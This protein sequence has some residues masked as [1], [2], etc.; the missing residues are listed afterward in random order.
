MRISI[1]HRLSL[2][3]KTAKEGESL[4]LFATLNTDW[5]Q[6]PIQVG[7]HADTVRAIAEWARS[8]WGPM[9]YDFVTAKKTAK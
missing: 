1:G 3:I 9:V 4:Y 5:G 8:S 2:D 6:I 7:A